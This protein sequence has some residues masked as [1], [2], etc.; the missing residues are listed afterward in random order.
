MSEEKIRDLE[1]LGFQW[2]VRD[3]RTPWATRLAEL[4]D[5]YEKHGDCDVPNDWP[6]NQ[7]LSFWVAKQRQVS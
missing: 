3:S 4:K 6:E 7:A 2:S 5:Y 1:G